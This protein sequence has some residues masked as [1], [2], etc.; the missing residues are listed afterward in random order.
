MADKGQVGSGISD[1]ALID[2]CVNT[3]NLIRESV[4]I[5]WDDE[6]EC[7]ITGRE[8]GTVE[9]VSIAGTIR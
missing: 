1:E 6:G 7:M 2:Y 5:D 4:K 3:F 9:R 8:V